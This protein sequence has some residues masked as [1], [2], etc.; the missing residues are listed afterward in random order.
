MIDFI[1]EYFT[2]ALNYG[3]WFSVFA[4]FVWGILSI[5]LSPCHLSSIP[6]VVGFLTKRNEA[7]N[8][9]LFLLSLIF[10]G[11][12][13]VTIILIGIITAIS[14]K[15]LGDIGTAGNVLVSFILIY[16]GLYLMDIAKIP[17]PGLSI[18]SQGNKG[19]F[20]ALTLGL[21]FGLGLG[22]CT[23]AFMAPVIVIVFKISSTNLFHSVLLLLAF[24]AGHCLVITFAGVSLTKVQALLNWNENTKAINIIKK[25]SGTL[26]VLA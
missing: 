2:N 1:F 25:V 11:G 5:I 8:K 21:L 14:G 19:Y 22:P 15:M 20:S 26:V 16:I 9:S 12:I 18:N 3:F 23:F 24:A 7:K 6:L 13:L 10:S 4:S 17:L